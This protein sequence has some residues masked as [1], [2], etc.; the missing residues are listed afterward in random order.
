MEWHGR[1]ERKGFTEARRTGCGPEGACS[2]GW[3]G[4]KGLACGSLPAAHPADL[5]AAPSLW[6]CS[7]ALSPDP[8][9][10]HRSRWGVQVWAAPEPTWQEGGFLPAS[11]PGM[12]CLEIWC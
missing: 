2:Q 5:P 8:P 1:R 12:R 9:G 6:V 4:R 3:H 11:F 10:W 7:E